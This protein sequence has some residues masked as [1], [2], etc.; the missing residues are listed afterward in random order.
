MIMMPIKLWCSFSK[1]YYAY[2]IECMTGVLYSYFMYFKS[3][4][5]IDKNIGMYFQNP[6][7]LYCKWSTYIYT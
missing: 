3:N 5:I 4:K 6:F 1:G 2:V 7:V